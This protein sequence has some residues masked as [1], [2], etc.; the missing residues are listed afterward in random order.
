MPAEATLPLIRV[1]GKSQITL[2][3]PLLRKFAL[4]TGDFLEATSTEEGI[5]LTP[6]AVVDR[7]ILENLKQSLQDL[8]Q[9]KVFGPFKNSAE[10]KRALKAKGLHRA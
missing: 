1:K 4:S 9:G 8:R 5:L 6:K 10:M 7:S 3:A 2:P